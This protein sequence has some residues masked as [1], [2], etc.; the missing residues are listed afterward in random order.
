MS[1]QTPPDPETPLT[2]EDLWPAYYEELHSVAV[3]VSRGEPRSPSL[4]PTLVLHEAYMKVFGGGVPEWRGKSYFVAS[5]A[6]A[7]RQYL[8]DR[9]RR[10]RV[11]RSALSVLPITDIAQ[12]SLSEAGRC[13]ER[14]ESLNGAIDALAEVHPRAAAI[15]EMRVAYDFTNEQLADL[16][17]VAERTVKADWTF[18]R[19]WLH[20][21]LSEGASGDGHG[22]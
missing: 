4:Q 12:A 16:V 19:A 10:R 13:P 11:E 15:V 6:R 18:A 22:A 1:L 7:M 2:P 5:M 14:V 8:V 17:G 9:A 21:R 3:A 20:A